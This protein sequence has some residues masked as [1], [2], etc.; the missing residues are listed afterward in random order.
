MH[1]AESPAVPEGKRPGAPPLRLW[2]IRWPSRFAWAVAVCSLAGLALS[3]LLFRLALEREEA[4]L[5]REHQRI[6]QSQMAAIENQVDASLHL[7]LALQALL[8]RDPDLGQHGLRRVYE[9]L[10]H[11]ARHRSSV[12]L[13]EWL[14]EVPARDLA[15]YENRQRRQRGNPAYFVWQPDPRR[16]RRSATGRPFFHVIEWIEP[17]EEHGAMIGLDSGHSAAT[18]SAIWRARNRGRLAATAGFRLAQDPPGRTS[19]IVYAPVCH[20]KGS[21][22][23]QLLGL[24]AIAIGVQP[25]L[26]SAMLP[27]ARPGFGVQIYDEGVHGDERV[28]LAERMVGSPATE[29]LMHVEAPLMERT[30]QVADRRWHL[31]FSGRYPMPWTRTWPAWTLLGASLLITAA[32][33]LFV[34]SLYRQNQRVQH[35]VRRRTRQLRHALRLAREATEAKSRFLAKI[36]HEIRTPLNGILGMTQLLMDSGL[37]R[38]HRESIA[39]I[40]NAGQHLLAVVNDTLDLS[41]I[42]AG[43]LT[44]AREPLELE[45]LLQEC[46]RIFRPV[47]EQK[48]LDLCVCGEGLPEWVEGDVTRLRQVLWNLLSNAVKFTSRGRVALTA[49]PGPT[50]PLVRFEVRD[51][52]PGIPAEDRARLFEPYFQS[53]VSAHTAEGTGLGLA[54]SRRLVELMGGTMGCESEPGVG[55][56]FWFEVP[57]PPVAAPQAGPVGPQSQCQPLG[58]R[59]L[60]VEDNRVNQTVSRRLLERLGCQAAI[61]ADGAEALAA[62]EKESFDVVLMDCQMPGM[63]GFEATRR[64]RAMGG[65]FQQIPIFALTALAVDTERTRCLE[66]GMNGVILKPVSLE[67]LQQ[68]LAQLPRPVPAQPLPQA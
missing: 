39:L 54:I 20:G 48:G 36:S 65:R 58:L 25:L 6:A 50:P 63:D 68:V 49:A 17:A 31:R 4:V 40:R 51:T 66:A 11:H 56:L 21:S 38:E 52:G 47:A 13:I 7:V 18:Q 64:I 60:L 30:I 44:L 22:G 43:K 16:G 62:I 53:R 27:G 33:Q 24:A 67:A 9:T 42:E 29:A 61:A 37:S 41:K 55:S 10:L 57:L 28:L 3:I 15:E 34:V 35:E 12:R 1:S 19:I 26:D 59:V 23:R 8:E 14:R 2:R 46:E 32:V 45:A 5:L